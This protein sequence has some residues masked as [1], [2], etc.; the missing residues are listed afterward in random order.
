MKQRSSTKQSFSPSDKTKIILVSTFLAILLIILGFMVGLLLRQ[1]GFKFSLPA[2][3]RQ[4]T[5]NFPPTLVAATTNCGTSTLVIGSTTYQIQTISSALDG[6]LIVPPNTSGIAYWVEGTNNNYVFLLSPTPENLALQSALKSGDRMT[7]FWQDC[8]FKE[9][10]ISAIQPAESNDATLSDQSTSGIT[11]LVRTSASA[12]GFAIRSME[13]QGTNT[14][15]QSEISADISLVDTKMSPDGTT[16]R[17]GVSIVNFGNSAF[18][19][20][21]SDISLVPENA[22][23]L[24]AISAEPPFPQEIKPGATQTIYFTFPYPAGPTATLKIF[25]VELDVQG[26]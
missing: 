23:A 22:E 6:S 3:S 5:P 16:I 10:T 24:G 11:I 18:T 26:Y 13:G 21:A 9:Y 25:S 17:I 14:S 20:S 4:A 7:V 8:H 1:S 15:S 19:I 12:S 2:L